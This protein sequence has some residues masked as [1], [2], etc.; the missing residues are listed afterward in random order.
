[1]RWRCDVDGMGVGLSPGRWTVWRNSTARGKVGCWLA[2]L[3]LCLQ[4]RQRERERSVC[5]FPGSVAMSRRWTGRQ[6][7]K[8][9]CKR[10]ED[11]RER[12]KGYAYYYY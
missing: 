11:R 5:V 8:S 4:G 3:M 1:M 6:D 2:L 12:R 9:N 10:F 7:W